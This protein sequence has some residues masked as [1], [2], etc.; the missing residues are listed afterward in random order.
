M[1]ARRIPWLKAM[2]PP[3]PPSRS[4]SSEDEASWRIFWLGKQDGL[5]HGAARLE[6]RAEAAGVAGADLA[7]PD[8][9]VRMPG[10]EPVRGC[11]LVPIDFIGSSR[12]VE[13]GELAFVFGPEVWQNLPFVDL[14]ASPGNFFPIVLRYRR[15][16]TYPPLPR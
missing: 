8:L 10:E 3:P 13:E 6:A 15:H 9:S 4:T 11:D 16:A 2:V 14:I 1:M 12:D 7:D 5:D